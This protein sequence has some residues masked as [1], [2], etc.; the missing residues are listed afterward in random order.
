[1]SRSAAAVPIG[2]VH[3]RTCKRCLA[4]IGLHS[5]LDDCTDPATLNAMT[6]LLRHIDV[7]AENGLVEV[8]R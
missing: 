1:M 5:T 6:N 2:A 4:V 7:P 8:R 3:P